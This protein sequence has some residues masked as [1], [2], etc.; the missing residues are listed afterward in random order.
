L[1]Y[2]SVQCSQQFGWLASRFGKDY[3][4]GIVFRRERGDEFRK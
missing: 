1:V 2:V 3:Q 4:V